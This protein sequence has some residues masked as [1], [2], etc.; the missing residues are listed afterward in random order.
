MRRKR[1]ASRKRTPTNPPATRATWLAPLVVLAGIAVY[2]N[3][4]SGVFLLDDM[5]RIVENPILKRPWHSG[6]WLNDDLR[7]PLVSLSLAIN[8]ALGGL[9]VWGYHAFNVAVHILAGLAL[10][11]VVRRTLETPAL[12]G[13][14][15][16]AAPWL[17]LSVALVWT[18]H[19][20]QTGSVTYIIQRCESMMGLFY[21]LTLYCVIRSA[22]SSRRSAWYAAAIVSCA[23]G[24]TCKAVMVTTPVVILLYDRIFLAR[25]FGELLRR[26]WA[27][28]L[29]LVASLAFLADGGLFQHVPE[30]LTALSR[31]KMVLS[32]APGGVSPLLY[33]ATQ[34]GVILHY[35]RLCFWPSALCL[36]YYWPVVASV[37]QVAPQ[38]LALGVLLLATVWALWW[39][40]RLGF[41]GAWF[42][43]ILA[44]TSSVH[45]LNN[46]AFEHRMYLPL[47]AVVVLVIL[48]GYWALSY[49]QT[50]FASMRRVIRLLGAAGVTLA[51]G[52]LGF[53]TLERNTVYASELAMWTDVVQKRPQNARAHC[54]VGVA[55]AKEGQLDAA[56]WWYHA[57]LAIDPTDA[58]AHNNLANALLRQGSADEAI[59]HYREAVRLWPGYAD[60]R[61]N[62]GGTLAKH[63]RLDEA[64]AEFRAVLKDEAANKLPRPA[65]MA[66]ALR[67][68]GNAHFQ[69][70]EYEQAVEAYRQ[71]LQLQPG[72]YRAHYNLALALKKLN[73]I[74]EAIEQY[75]QALRLEPGHAGARA[76][77]DALLGNR[78]DQGR[79]P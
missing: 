15:A 55:L 69:K 68:L 32:Q 39:R 53:A 34:S 65:I 44:P 62:L 29:G 26:R 64:I 31:Q 19:P 22:D 48:I 41:L 17:A 6:A 16:R 4:F 38:A 42:F 73:R 12:R 63:D 74:D 20:L 75:R 37:K 30:A 7:R 77:L 70:R 46:V 3:G 57:A 52:A 8:H 40:P 5:P 9:D 23:L 61:F 76:E 27:L 66:R 67:H 14:Y 71:S 13:T 18:V 79:S 54:H 58:V 2:A 43:L 56:I 25:G 47:A 72:Q 59:Q 60:A 1:S 45:P 78:N 10:F 49:L 50:R 35:L 36:D 11:G 28:Y 24:M 51:V 33:A 21:L